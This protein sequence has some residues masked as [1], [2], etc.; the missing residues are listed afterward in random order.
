MRTDQFLNEIAKAFNAESF[1]YPSYMLVSTDSAYTPAVTDTSVPG[2]VG[3]RFSITRSRSNNVVTISGIR[4]GAVVTSTSGDVLYA[5][6]DNSAISSGTLTGVASLPSL[7]HTTS[8][9][10]E[11]QNQITVNR[12]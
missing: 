4:S 8:F 7:T 1:V 11:F 9:D 2:E 5:Y 10:L 12:R 3:S 6:G